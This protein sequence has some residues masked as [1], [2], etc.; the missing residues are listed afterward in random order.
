MRANQKYYD[1]CLKKEVIITEEMAE[2]IKTMDKEVASK[3][4]VSVEDAVIVE[5]TKEL[6]V[7]DSKEM[8]L[9]EAHKAYKEKTGND[10]S[11]RYK[12]DLEWILSKLK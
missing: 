11:N 7:E 4:W 3:R 1:T 8:T 9:E 2:V 10:V 5:E 6:I 12:N